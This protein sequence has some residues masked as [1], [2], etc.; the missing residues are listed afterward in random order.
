[1]KY[2]YSLISKR[3][4]RRVC[5]VS[6]SYV[7]GLSLSLSL[8][9]ALLSRLI[10]LATR[11]RLAAHSRSVPVAPFRH[12]TVICVVAP[13]R[14]TTTAE[15]PSLLESTNPCRPTAVHIGAL[16][17]F[18]LQS[19]RLNICYTTKI[20]IRG[21]LFHVVAPFGTRPLSDLSGRTFRHSA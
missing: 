4:Y 11:R 14:H 20:C 1:M 5:G 19:S 13:L 8:P 7:A 9:C 6:R 3:C 17:H 21:C 2:D 12:R 15:H 10:S 16:V 18:S